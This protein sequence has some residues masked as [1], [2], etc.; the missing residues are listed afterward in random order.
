ME[1][2]PGAGTGQAQPAPTL[3][4]GRSPQ[5]DADLSTDCPPTAAGGMSSVHKKMQ[6]QRQRE[7]SQG[8]E[9]SGARTP[10]TDRREQAQLRRELSQCTNQTDRT[11][12]AEC[13]RQA[14]EAREA[15]PDAESAAGS[16][17]A[18]MQNR[19]AQTNCR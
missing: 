10:L 5:A 2:S 13:V 11:A 1:G 16:H 15:P 8:A 6:G 7:H 19:E 14:W 3:P 18:M 4:T 12:R 17:M 9:Q